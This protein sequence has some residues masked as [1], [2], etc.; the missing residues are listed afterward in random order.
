MLC[1]L[2]KSK[3]ASPRRPS[4]A[5]TCSPDWF[6]GRCRTESWF[7]QESRA[8]GLSFLMGRLL[9]WCGWG[10]PPEASGRPRGAQS[11][12]RAC[13]R[14]QLRAGP[15]R[16]PCAATPSPPLHIPPEAL[17]PRCGIEPHL[18]LPLPNRPA[19]PRKLGWRCRLWMCPRG[20]L[21]LAGCLPA[22]PSTSRDSGL[23]SRQ[24]VR[25]GCSGRGRAVRGAGEAS[26]LSSTHTG[27]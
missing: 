1:T 12:D 24:S 21:T 22:T 25:P 4:G 7:G 23:F 17:A 6:R 26:G 14:T 18:P 5:A 27:V 20:P 19:D 2:S 10:P 13:P 11:V 3:K 9:R 16:A 15:G 8:G